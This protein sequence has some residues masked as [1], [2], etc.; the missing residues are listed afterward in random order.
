MALVKI[1]K[2]CWDNTLVRIYLQKTSITECIPCIVFKFEIT[3]QAPSHTISVFHVLHAEVKSASVNQSIETESDLGEIIVSYREWR[4]WARQRVNITLEYEYVHQ[5]ALPHSQPWK[6]NIITDSD[7]WATLREVDMFV[8]LFR[9]RPVYVAASYVSIQFPHGVSY[10][11]SWSRPVDS[12]KVLPPGRKI[13]NSF[14][15]FCNRIFEL[16]LTIHISW[17]IVNGRYYI[18]SLII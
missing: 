9:G 13:L 16:C 18:T 15:R 12:R 10:V 11:T 5:I 14:H 7:S 3:R 17:V 8:R 4:S 6:V 2:S 1:K